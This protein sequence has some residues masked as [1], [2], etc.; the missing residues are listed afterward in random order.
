MQKV[1][2]EKI[3]PHA[4]SV[5][6]LAIAQ[7]PSFSEMSKTHKEATASNTKAGLVL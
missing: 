6:S 7:L 5:G 4:F 2:G 1:E 3:I